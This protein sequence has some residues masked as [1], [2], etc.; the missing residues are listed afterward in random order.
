MTRIPV[1]LAQEILRSDLAA[2]ADS[3]A[4]AQ[5]SFACFG[6][7]S[8][9]ASVTEF[10]ADFVGDFAV[11]VVGNELGDQIADVVGLL[12]VQCPR[13][14]LHRRP[15]EVLVVGAVEVPAG[16]RVGDCDGAV[17]VVIESFEISEAQ[18]YLCESADVAPLVRSYSRYCSAAGA[19][20]RAGEAG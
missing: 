7:G 1:R 3:D 8:V 6:V 18:P 9:A 14:R 16:C 11:H 2:H 20:G 5:R 19:T 17:P 4:C 13:R 15:S 12:L 10:V